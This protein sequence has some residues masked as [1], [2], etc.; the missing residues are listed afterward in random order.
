MRKFWAIRSD[1]RFL[2]FPLVPL[3]TYQQVMHSFVWFED[4]LS[5]RKGFILKI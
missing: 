4:F 3:G 1:W 2:A 5:A